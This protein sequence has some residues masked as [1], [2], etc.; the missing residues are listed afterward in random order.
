MGQFPA[1]TGALAP[2]DMWSQ[3]TAPLRLA[4]GLGPADNGVR[5]WALPGLVHLASR[6]ER[7]QSVATT[8]GPVSFIWP[9]WLWLAGVGQ[10]PGPAPPFHH[11]LDTSISLSFLICKLVEGGR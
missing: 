2:R 7:G 9:L 1:G 10:C 5:L 11:F 3:S 6:N 8:S 4:S